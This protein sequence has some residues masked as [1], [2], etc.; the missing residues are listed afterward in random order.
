MTGD[1]Q[2]EIE[3]TLRMPSSTRLLSFFFFLGFCCLFFLLL[4][5]WG[6]GN[7]V[8]WDMCT[9]PGKIRAHD[10]SH[11]S[12]VLLSCLLHCQGSKEFPNP[13]APRFPG[14]FALPQLPK[15]LSVPTIVAMYSRWT[16]ECTSALT[17]TAVCGQPSCP[18]ILATFPYIRY[19]DI[20][21]AVV[22]LKDRTNTSSSTSSN[23]TSGASSGL[24][25]SSSGIK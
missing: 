20:R 1:W 7:W 25:L 17:S 10:Y 3:R 16:H 5:F 2:C 23:A 24:I 8:G 21:P 18:I 19:T 9:D 15:P 14:V 6:N 22:F 13:G 4:A 11:L 12:L